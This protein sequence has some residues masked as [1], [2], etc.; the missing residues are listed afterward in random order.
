MTY[1]LREFPWHDSVE[2]DDLNAALVALKL[3]APGTYL[4]NNGICYHR[5][6][7]SIITFKYSN[8]IY[9]DYLIKLQSEENSEV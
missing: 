2:F 7:D 9:N 4:V 3:S 5:Y 8:H 6:R 1:H